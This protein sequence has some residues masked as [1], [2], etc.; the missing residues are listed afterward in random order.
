[1]VMGPTGPG[2][3]NDCTGEG[4]QQFTRNLTPQTVPQILLKFDMG[5]FHQTLSGSSDFCYADP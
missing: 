5:E 1:M 4:Q 3:K 2:T